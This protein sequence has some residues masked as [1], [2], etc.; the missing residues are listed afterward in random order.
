MIKAII[1]DYDGV[2][3]KSIDAYIP[4]FQKVLTKH[5]Y[6]EPTGEEIRKNYYMTD[7]D[8]LQVLSGERSEE[9]IQAMIDDPEP[10]P[11]DKVAVASK[12]KETLEALKRYKLGVVSNAERKHVLEPL[13]RSGIEGYFSVIVTMEDTRVHKPDPAPIKLALS[14]IGVEPDQAVYVGDYP[15]DV[16][17]GKAAGTK[18]IYLSDIP[19][20]GEDARV[21]VFSEI[22]DAIRKI[23]KPHT[24]I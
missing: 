23:E 17:A 21:H 7:H 22:P 12:V 15:T 20:G 24:N 8:L 18:V 11:Y 14:K 16:A 6:A 3:V 4:Y 13:V 2:L 1:F 5:G 10:E 9:K 19:D